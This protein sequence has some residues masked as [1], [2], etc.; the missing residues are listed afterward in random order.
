M[1]MSVLTHISFNNF[2]TSNSLSAISSPPSRLDLI[3]NNNGISV[4]SIIELTRLTTFFISLI[5]DKK[6]ALNS[7]KSGPLGTINFNCSFTSSF[8]F[9]VIVIQIF[10]FIYWLFLILLYLYYLIILFFTINFFL[11]VNYIHHS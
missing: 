8:F 11:H 1:Y 3:V 6:S 4:L 7:I 5:S 9:S 10:V 2:K